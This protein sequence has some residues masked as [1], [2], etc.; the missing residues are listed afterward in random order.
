MTRPTDA[1]AAGRCVLNSVGAPPWPSSAHPDRSIPLSNGHDV[2][3]Y[4]LKFIPKCVG[5]DSLQAHFEHQQSSS[6]LVSAIVPGT[7]M[8]GVL[9]AAGVPAHRLH[10]LTI[11]IRHHP[12][13]ELRAA[14]VKPPSPVPRTLLSHSTPTFAA[15]VQEPAPLHLPTWSH[16]HKH[17]TQLVIISSNRR[18]SIEQ[19]VHEQLAM[20][21]LPPQCSTGMQIH[22]YPTTHRDPN[23]CYKAR[24]I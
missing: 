1:A 20:S 9:Q 19:V 22:T 8:Q 18:C 5:H 24:S 17:R 3:T 4:H 6:S 21:S 7:A 16:A 23:P 11:I 14:S 2:I 13:T 15:I 10:L 12:T